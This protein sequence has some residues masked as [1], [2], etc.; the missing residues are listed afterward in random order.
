VGCGWL[1]RSGEVGIVPDSKKSCPVVSDSSG[2]VGLVCGMKCGKCERSVQLR[3][4]FAHHCIEAF[5]RLAIL[6]ASRRRVALRGFGLQVSRCDSCH[7]QAYD[8][9]VRIGS[10]LAGGGE[11][12]G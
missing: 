10:Q 6:H 1:E 8:S 7:A 11:M 5:R 12:V 2:G 9:S 3:N 4:E